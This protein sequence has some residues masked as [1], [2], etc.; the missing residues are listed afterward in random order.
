MPVFTMNIAGYGDLPITPTFAPTIDINRRPNG[1]VQSITETWDCSGILPVGGGGSAG[2]QTDRNNLIAAFQLPD[3]TITF[4]ADGS[5]FETIGPATHVRGAQFSDFDVQASGGSEWVSHLRYKFVV[6][7]EK[8]VAIPDVLSA[9][10]TV[11]ISV[12]A[13]GKTTTSID[14][15]ARGPGASAY[16]TASKPGG[17]NSSR[18]TTNLWEETASGSFTLDGVE[19][20]GGTQVEE[21]VSIDKGLFPLSFARP[22]RSEQ[23]IPF[24]GSRTPTA[25]SISGTVTT[26]TGDPVNPPMSEDLEKYLTKRTMSRKSVS[27][28]ETDREEVSYAMDFLVPHE[29]TVE[30][31]MAERAKLDPGKFAGEGS[32][33]K[34]KNPNAGTTVHG[35]VQT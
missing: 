14:V 28:G 17:A 23:P 29:V 1:M 13:D 20:G 8:A 6:I 18:I 26:T 24:W 10:K 25:V 15:S 5:A 12:D 7:G 4:K 19:G 16:V 31:I 32:K 35:K 9:D 11:T 21:D 33:P 30:E 27:G 3:T 2:L 34:P 22:T